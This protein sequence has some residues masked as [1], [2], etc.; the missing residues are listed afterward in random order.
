MEPDA[1]LATIL[2]ECLARMQEGKPIDVCLASNDEEYDYL[3]PLL[4][5]GHYISSLPK[6]QPSEEFRRTAKG[7]LMAR[8]YEEENGEVSIQHKVK[9]VFSFFDS[10]NLAVDQLC[11]TLAGARKIALPVT[12][13]LALIIACVM[14][15]TNFV[16]P[17]PARADNCVLS[18]ISGTVEVQAPEM[19]GQSGTEGMTLDA[20]TLITTAK[21]STGLLTFFD[22]STL[23]LESETVIEIQQL[24]S[25]ED[26]S[27]TIVLSQMQGC[28]WS[29]VV[30]MA[31]DGSRYQINTP[32]AV[33]VAHGSRFLVDVDE[34]GQTTEQTTE[35][36]VSITAQGEEVFVPAGLVTVV[37]LGATP[38]EPIVA[39]DLGD[40]GPQEL[41]HQGPANGNP[42][43]N[44][45]P[46]YGQDNDRNNGPGI[47]IAGNNEQGQGNSGSQG[48]GN[49]GGQSQGNSGSQG[50]GNSG[51]QSQGNS[52]SQSQG[53]SGGQGQGN[54]NA[55]K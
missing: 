28:T 16:S 34:T 21:D 12:L 8:L 40:E 53:N 2:D 38:T 1:K 41:V 47:G 52:G 30:T 14:G 31:D 20:G 15:G 55:K 23:K 17:S 32:S 7:R 9:P 27:V 43:Q 13:G 42:H 10:L 29:N 4:Y 44:A 48:Q 54:G 45:P 50:Q 49:S 19:D 5:A 6:V 26:Q 33:A 36:F 11:Q 22:G 35:G 25:G 46:A 3:A 18:D 39:A 37:E 24:E 51:S